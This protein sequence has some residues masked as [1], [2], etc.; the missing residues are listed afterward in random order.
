MGSDGRKG[1]LQ[2]A[3]AYEEGVGAGGAA[4]STLRAACVPEYHTP[5]ESRGRMVHAQPCPA[6]GWTELRLSLLR[7]RSPLSSLLSTVE[8]LDV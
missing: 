5:Y 3:D 6:G 2:V 1:P 8:T 7:A 4:A